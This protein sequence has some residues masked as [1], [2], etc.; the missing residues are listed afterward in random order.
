MNRR[1]AQ[2]FWRFLSLLIFA[3]RISQ[4]IKFTFDPSFDIAFVYCERGGMYVSSGKNVF[5]A[6]TF[7]RQSCAPYGAQPINSSIIGRQLSFRFLSV[8]L[9]S[10]LKN[11]LGKS[12][13][14]KYNR[15]FKKFQRKKGKNWK[16]YVKIDE[17]RRKIDKNARIG[18]FLLI[19]EKICDI[20]LMRLFQVSEEF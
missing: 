6:A 5:P 11:L 10:L 13:Y 8:Y 1:K 18:A 3:C 20:I 19:M 7:S 9:L 2:R 16:N 4:S 12:I 14:R 15:Y 17:N